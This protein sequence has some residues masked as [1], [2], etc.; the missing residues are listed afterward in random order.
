MEVWKPVVGYEGL[1]D[2]SNLG[3]VR[4]YHASAR[5]GYHNKEPHVLSGGDVRGYRQIILVDRNSGK[6]TALVH[7]VVARA[8]LGEPPTANH[9]VN[10]KDFNKANNVPENLEWMLHD[11]NNRY[12]SKFI[13][14]L[15]GE[16][17]S[18]CKLNDAKV[19]TI[20]ARYAAGNTT[21]NALAAHYGV[22][23]PTIHSIIHRR[24]WAH[25]K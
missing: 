23:N 15:R 1:Y 2:V 14:R 10:H 3:R 8:F 22:S 6:K 7:R 19:R 20:R 5:R 17:R 25:V 12:S 24:K 11:D 16:E 4:S 13:P 21:L 9:E 18:D